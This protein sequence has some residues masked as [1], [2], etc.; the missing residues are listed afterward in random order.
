MFREVVADAGA[1]AADV[2]GAGVPLSMMAHGAAS[3]GAGGFSSAAHPASTNAT[4][5]SGAATFLSDEV[6]ITRR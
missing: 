3:L 1:G 2:F 5:A 6:R 4:P